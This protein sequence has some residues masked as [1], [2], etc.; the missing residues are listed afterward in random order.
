MA[1]QKELTKEETARLEYLMSECNKSFSEEN[2]IC[3]SW[4]K[5]IKK[6]FE[7]DYKPEAQTEKKTIPNL[8]VGSEL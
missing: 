2:T 3:Q 5:A 1:K 8:V 7:I 6:E 4:A